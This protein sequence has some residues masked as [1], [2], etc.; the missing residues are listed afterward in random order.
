VALPVIEPLHDESPTYLQTPSLK[1][2]TPPP[3]FA[4]FSSLFPVVS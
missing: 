1:V 4:L 3:R 2:P